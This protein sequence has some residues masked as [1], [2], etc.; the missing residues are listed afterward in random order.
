ITALTAGCLFL[1]CFFFSPLFTSMATYV[2]A[3]ALIYVGTKLILR[4]REFDRKRI[5]IF[6][7]GACLILYVGIT[8]NI[9]NAVLYGL[10][11]YTLI[12]RIVEKK[13]PVSH[14][15]IIL[16]FAAVHVLLN[17]VV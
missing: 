4:F 8:F 13:K 7:F 5:A 16:I 9:G 10:A 12:N 11:L 6:L 15:W 14:W 1:L 2:A 3:P 17:Y